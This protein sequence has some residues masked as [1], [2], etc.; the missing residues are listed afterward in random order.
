MPPT[1]NPRTAIV[2]GG[3]SG[4]GAAIAQRLA[5]DGHRVAT[6]DITPTEGDSSYVVDVTDRG[7]IDA[8]LADIHSALGSVTILVNAAG[9]E[10]TARFLDISR[11]PSGS[12]SSISRSTACFTPLRRFCPTCS[13][14]AGDA[15]STSHRPART[16]APR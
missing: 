15:S 12:A 4:I 14:Q 9:A 16:P 3:S 13:G 5:S 2:T 8:A 7:Q 1:S 6:P 11:S 10:A